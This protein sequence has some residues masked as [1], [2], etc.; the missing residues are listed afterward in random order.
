[1][2]AGEHHRAQVQLHE[3]IERFLGDVVQHRV[4]CRQA[5]ANVVVE[6]VDLAE[7]RDNG[8]DKFTNAVFI[9]DV[10]IVGKRGAALPLDHGCRL[11]GGLEID[12]ADT[13]SGSFAGELQSRG[14]AVA[15][16]LS[17]RLPA[18]DDERRFAFEHHSPIP[19]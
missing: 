17:G 4:P 19:A 15:D 3:A 18:S 8:G 5:R 14:A 7:S 11:L 6:N 12:V 1:M 9:D 2:L 13:N 10:D 16:R